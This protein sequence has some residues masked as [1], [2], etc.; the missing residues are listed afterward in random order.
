MLGREKSRLEEPVL[1]G[2]YDWMEA[3]DGSDKGG[4]VPME[5][6]LA[7]PK[8]GRLLLPSEGRPS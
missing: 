6:R 1:G 5:S 4:G 8:E 7:E 3:E 2:E